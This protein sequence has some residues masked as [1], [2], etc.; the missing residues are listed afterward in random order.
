[1]DADVKGCVGSISV[2]PS[3]IGLRK[4]LPEARRCLLARKV[5]FRPCATQTARFHLASAT[6]RPTTSG[7]CSRC[8][9][10]RA[11][12]RFPVRPRHVR[13]NGSRTFLYAQI[14]VG[15]Q[16]GAWRRRAAFGMWIAI[17]LP[18]LAE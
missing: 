15:V 16:G 18:I 13:L 12:D 9:L 2:E 8:S 1:M 10:T 14:T 11:D 7:P 4:T 17:R 6:S 5:L 3:G